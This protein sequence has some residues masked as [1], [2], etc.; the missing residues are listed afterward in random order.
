MFSQA[1]PD[2]VSNIVIAGCGYAGMV[3]AIR[4]MHH[5]RGHMNIYLVNDGDEKNIGGV[6]YSKGSADTSHFQNLQAGRI[7]L[8]REDP[9]HYIRWAKHVHGLDLNESSPVPRQLFG[10]YCWDVLWMEANKCNLANLYVCNGKIDKFHETKDAVEVRTSGSTTLQMSSELLEKDPMRAIAV[11]N[12]KQMPLSVPESGAPFSLPKKCDY[13]VAATGHL[14]A[15]KPKALEHFSQNTKDVIINQYSPSAYTVIEDAA[16][17]LTSKDKVLIMGTGL[18]AFDAAVSVIKRCDSNDMPEFIFCS[19]NGRRH[20][21]YAADHEHKAYKIKCPKLLAELLKKETIALSDIEGSFKAVW[22][23][24]TS[25]VTKQCI[26]EL[27]KNPDLLPE[28][29]LKAME[30]YIAKLIQKMS[31]EDFKAAQAKYGSLITTSRIGMVPEIGN[32][33]KDL[34][35]EG[36]ARFIKGEL[37]SFENGVAT[38]KTKDGKEEKITPALTVNATGRSFD[39]TKTNNPLWKN[40]D[41]V[42]HQKTGMGVEITGEGRLVRS[43]GTPHERVYGCGVM[44]IGKEIED[45]GRLG[46]FTTSQGPTKSQAVEIAKNINRDISLPI[47]EIAEFFEYEKTHKSSED[48]LIAYLESKNKKLLSTEFK[49]A[50]N[51][52]QNLFEMGLGNFEEHLYAETIKREAP[53]K[54]L[55][56]KEQD[57]IEWGAG[58]GMRNLIERNNVSDDG[59]RYLLAIAAHIEFERGI[60]RA[61]D[62]C[63]DFTTDPSS[64]MAAV[65]AR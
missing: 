46:A 26:K 24:A 29:T 41:F 16:K 6:A 14:E 60:T 21:I 62:R 2:E 40:S 3:S 10:E 33:I 20:P 8:L 25:D 32:I 57:F 35:A 39:Y 51:Y 37:E 12:G 5:A 44:N 43:N 13:F 52:M 64:V 54:V 38:I 61:M 50:L 53:W 56:D 19:R 31:P 30:P 27:G 9:N 11:Y 55:A 42:P 47:P 58:G 49:A 34:E 65:T 45:N 1:H 17:R 36:K 18:S 7:S 15:K 23:E 48:S 63:K 4:L 59:E 28:R 22:D